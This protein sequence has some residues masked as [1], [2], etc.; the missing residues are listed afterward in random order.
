MSLD[1]FSQFVADLSAGAQAAGIVAGQI[2]LGHWEQPAPVDGQPVDN[3]WEDVAKNGFYLFIESPKARADF[4]SRNGNFSLIAK[5]IGSFPADE[6]SN[7][8]ALQL[9]TA[10]LLDA[11]ANMLIGWNQGGNRLP[12]NVDFARPE[13][14]FHEKPYIGITVF[15]IEGF[16]VVGE[17]ANPVL[18]PPVT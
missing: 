7:L 12:V 16:F 1:V 10:Q 5:L 2:T 4:V 11:W 6:S 9:Q 3:L 14:L 15:A 13:M 17:A 18:N 8:Q